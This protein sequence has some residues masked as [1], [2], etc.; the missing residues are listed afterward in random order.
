LTC[1]QGCS[2]GLR[3]CD[4]KT[5]KYR[6][7]GNLRPADEVCDGKDNDCDGR[8]DEN[9]MQPCLFDY[10]CANGFYCA[11]ERCHKKKP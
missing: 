4:Y 9:C 2:Q 1:Y 8:V 11:R 5:R 7:C 6:E 10:H 3:S